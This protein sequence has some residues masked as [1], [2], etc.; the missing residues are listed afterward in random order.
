[1]NLLGPNATLDHLGKNYKSNLLKTHLASKHLAKKI[2][3]KKRS[4]KHFHLREN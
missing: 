3:R 4:S 1:M 2:G